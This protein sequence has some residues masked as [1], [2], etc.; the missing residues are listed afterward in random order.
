MTIEEY[1][2]MPPAGAVFRRAVGGVMRLPDRPDRVPG[3]ELQV[4]GVRVNRDHLWR[5]DRVCGFRLGDTL[6]PTYPHVLAFPL[7]MSLMSRPDFPFSLLGIVHVANTMEIHRPVDAGERLDLAVRAENLRDHERG[8]VVDLVA[9]AT[10]DGHV[11]WAGRSSYLRKE[12]RT[13]DRDGRS[14]RDRPSTPARTALWRVPADIGRRYAEASEDRNPIHTSRVVARLLGFPG[15]IAHGMWTKARCLAALEGRLPDAYTAEVAFK[16]PIVLPSTV[17][18][19]ASR[20]DTGWEVAVHG[21]SSGK[22]HLTGT[23]TSPG[24]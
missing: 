2:T 20:T 14:E 7:A 8:R 21:A 24:G 11:V 13:G 12:A 6:P 22:P 1:G 3:V 18:F 5:Y 19:A 15:R 4:R 17:A 16:A 9:T 23:I 10:V